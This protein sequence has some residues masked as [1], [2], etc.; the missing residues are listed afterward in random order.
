[1]CDIEKECSM[2][3]AIIEATISPIWYADSQNQSALVQIALRRL[4]DDY[5]D[6]CTEECMRSRC[7]AYVATRIGANRG[8]THAGQ[9]QLGLEMWVD[10]ADFQLD[11]VRGSTP[12]A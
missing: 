9:R 3:D 1:M 8:V 7:E 6:F 10:L 11:E 5:G 4:R 12:F 2:I